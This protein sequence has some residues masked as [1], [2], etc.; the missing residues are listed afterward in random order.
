MVFSDFD[1]ATITFSYPV[2]QEFVVKLDWICLKVLLE[3]GSKEVLE[4]VYEKYQ[5][6]TSDAQ[7]IVKV[8]KEQIPSD[9]AG[10]SLF[11]FFMC[12][13]SDLFF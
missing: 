6:A 9:D 4:K 7:V 8:T 3:N 1:G 13:L 12:H 5:I 10:K 2:E 11:L